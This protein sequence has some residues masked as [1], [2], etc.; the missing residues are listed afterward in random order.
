[1]DSVGLFWLFYFSLSV[2]SLFLDMWHLVF[3]SKYSND[4]SFQKHLIVWTFYSSH[5]YE[6][7]NLDYKPGEFK[8]GKLRQS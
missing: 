5:F 6:A 7:D 8:L 3:D 2:T 1:M 4:L